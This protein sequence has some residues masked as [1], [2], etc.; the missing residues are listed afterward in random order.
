VSAHCNL[1][2]AE[3]SPDVVAAYLREEIE[4]GRVI[5]PESS[6]GVHISPFRV[7]PKNNRLGKWRLIVDISSPQDKN[8]NN[9]IS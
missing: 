4:L 3:K 1:F 7:I 8:V 5:G 2:S 9:G 6:F